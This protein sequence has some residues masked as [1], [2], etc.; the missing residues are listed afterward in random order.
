MW[1]KKIA[2]PPPFST[3]LMLSE[4]FLELTWSLFSMRS[5][6]VCIYGPSYSGSKCRGSLESR[7]SGPLWHSQSLSFLAAPKLIL[8]QQA[9]CWQTRLLVTQSLQPSVCLSPSVGHPSHL[10]IPS[11]THC[12]LNNSCSFPVYR[13][14][15]ERYKLTISSLGIDPN[16]EESESMNTCNFL[17][18]LIT[19]KRK[20]NG[21][22]LNV[23][24]QRKYL[25]SYTENIIQP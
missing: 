9:S 3:W 7:S 21:N 6:T 16:G 13:K 4:H 1:N 24:Q 17:F 20:S 2:A 19:H 15:S 11:P 23:C 5:G 18:N 8:Q 14:H 22:H 12:H 10:G 25:N